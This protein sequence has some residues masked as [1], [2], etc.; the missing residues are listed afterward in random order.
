M[1]LIFV[2][3]F[4]LVTSQVLY[5]NW[6][7]YIFASEQI[8]PIQSDDELMYYL[9]NPRPFSTIFNSPRYPQITDFLKKNYIFKIQEN[10]NMKQPTHDKRFPGV[11]WPTGMP[12]ATTFG[13]TLSPSFFQQRYSQTNKCEQKWFEFV[14]MRSVP[15]TNHNCTAQLD[16][17]DKDFKTS[18]IY[19]NLIGSGFQIPRCSIIQGCGVY[20]SFQQQDFKNSNNQPYTLCKGFVSTC[21]Y[22]P[23]YF[24]PELQNVQGK[25]P[26]V[27]YIQHDRIP[28]IKI[29]NI[30]VIDVRPQLRMQ[31]QFKNGQLSGGSCMKEE[32]P[33]ANLTL[34]QERTQTGKGTF[35]NLYYLSPT[36]FTPL[37][38]RTF[39]YSEDKNYQCNFPQPRC[40]TGV[41]ITINNCREEVPKIDSTPLVG[42]PSDSFISFF[43]APCNCPKQCVV[44]LDTDRLVVIKDGVIIYSNYKGNTIKELQINMAQQYNEIQIPTEHRICQSIWQGEKIPKGCGTVT[45]QALYQEQDGFITA[46]RPAASLLKAYEFSSSL[47]IFHQG[48]F[49]PL[50]IP[51]VYCYEPLDAVKFPFNSE[52]PVLQPYVTP[53]VVSIKDGPNYLRRVDFGNVNGSRLYGEDPQFISPSET[54]KPTMGSCKNGQYYMYNGSLEVISPDG[55][56]LCVSADFKSIQQSCFTDK[57]KL[58]TKV[59]IVPKTFTAPPTSCYSLCINPLGCT[60][61]ESTSPL[62]QA[63]QLLATE[64]NKFT[65]NADF[66]FGIPLMNDSTFFPK[67]ATVDFTLTQNIA[68]DKFVELKTIVPK[69][70]KDLEKFKAWFTPKGYTDGNSVTQD[71]DW[72]SIY[73]E[74]QY[75]SQSD[76]DWTSWFPWALSRRSSRQ[77][78]TLNFAMNAVINGLNDLIHDVNNNFV[79]VQNAIKLSAKQI[80]LNYKAIKDVYDITS[81]SI[82]VL[83]SQLST[84]ALRV[85]SIEY[86]TA[87]LVTLNQ[88]Y[89]DVKNIHLDIKTRLEFLNQRK[90]ACRDK[91][92]YCND[93]L[94]PVLSHAEI[95]TPTHSTLIVY[96]LGSDDCDKQYLQTSICKG[97][98]LYIAMFPCVFFSTNAQDTTVMRNM[99]DNTNCTVPYK[100]FDTCRILPTDVDKISLTNLFNVKI[101]PNTQTPDKIIFKYEGGNITKFSEK[102]DS[103]LD[104]IQVAKPLSTYL[105]KVIDTY[106]SFVN[107]STWTWLDYLIAGL[108]TFLV[109]LLLPIILPCLA[110]VFSILRACCRSL[111]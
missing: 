11:D 110:A 55:V 3:I 88:L 5:P 85:N 78:N 97:G 89:N 25:P 71:L 92:S 69:Y 29:G 68:I 45:T 80:E 18:N 30:T 43:E 6:N 76:I 27:Q 23:K 87:K 107:V 100:V 75:N 46:N 65:N 106:L 77:I 9:K 33:V 2:F 53:Q 99:T 59:Y 17:I 49:G 57:L 22:G 74:N 15:K 54:I 63:C 105:K 111:S 35:M 60:H 4:P 28:T 14:E 91:T 101:T 32:L 93:G 58:K 81:T 21:K 34:Q 24:T 31:L 64:I 72:L 66:K 98:K 37:K 86:M 84:L 7:K 109:I 44:F 42:L 1:L 40:P 95:D 36:V 96:Y 70:S 108:I 19:S 62:M 103:F 38:V 79:Q 26:P 50:T 39:E 47:R 51:K 52:T 48:P 56:P 61:E 73:Q 82:S 90:L 13:S 102:V 104:K 41:V 83:S 10:L 20:S 67:P 94:G 12:V 16:Q 8:I